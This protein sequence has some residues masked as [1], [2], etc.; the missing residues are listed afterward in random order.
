[1]YAYPPA[2][3]KIVLVAL[4]RMPTLQEVWDDPSILLQYP[5]PVAQAILEQ[6]QHV[7]AAVEGSS[8]VPPTPALM[9]ISF[10]RYTWMDTRHILYLGEEVA[11]A[12]DRSGAIIVCMPP[13]HAKSHTCSV[14]TPFWFL[15]QRPEDQVLFISYEASFARKWGVKVRGLIELYGDRYGLHID[16][17]RTA[18]DDWALT[19]GG[20]MRCVGVGGGIAGNPAKLLIG[21]DLIK[22]REEAHSQVIREKTWDWWE[23]TVVQRIEPD[24]TTVLIGTRYHEDDVLGRAIKHSVAGTGIHFDEITLRA[25]AEAD[26]PLGRE[27]GEGLWTNHAKPGGA[28]GQEFYDEREAGVSAYTWHS[29]YQQ[30]PSPPGGNMVDPEWWDY[31][32]PNEF[33]QHVDQE[34]ETWDLALDSSKKTD[35][36]HAGLVMARSGARVFLRDAYHEHSKIAASHKLDEKTVIGTIR[37]WTAM[38][39]AAQQKLVERS[40]AGPMLVQTLH[41]EIPGLIAWPPKGRQ[42]GSKEACLNACVPI[43]RSRNVLL[44]LNPDGTKPK[45][46]V[47]FVEELRQF[48]N[49]PHD[50]YVDAFSQGMDFLLPSVRAAVDAAQADALQVRTLRSPEEEHAAALH[51]LLHKLSDRNLRQIPRE[52]EGS[53]QY[54]RRTGAPPV[55]FRLV[56]GS[57]AGGKRRAGGMW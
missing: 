23:T 57:M 1:M 40:L 25:K 52:G 33:P 20:G 24:T 11:A 3:V 13:R 7:R 51:A 37:T 5:A 8:S 42:K 9:A 31:Y 45:W 32:R 22:D 39:P 46:V 56:G 41:S 49:A 12:V 10:P 17:K 53:G 47:D 54:F 44:P 35:S 4:P 50:D 43:I 19:T 55:P 2:C 34:I 27:I 15:A 21:D 28:W 29:V 18:G 16:P 26:D 14:W 36:Y 30:R 38:F 48:P 6:F